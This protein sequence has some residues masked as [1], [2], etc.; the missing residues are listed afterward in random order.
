MACPQ[1]KSPNS[2][3]G[4]PATPSSARCTDSVSRVERC[5]RNQLGRCSRRRDNSGQLPNRRRLAASR[6][7]LWLRKARCL[8]LRPSA[9]WT[10]RLAR[11]RFSL[12]ALTCASGP[13]GIPL[14]QGSPSVDVGRTMVRTALSTPGWP[15]SP[16]RRRSVQVRTSSLARS[17]ATYKNERGL[18]NICGA[19]CHLYSE[20]RLFLF[21]LK[22]H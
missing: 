18:A 9:M 17:S 6:S 22:T 14:K 2:W 20:Q 4:L 16:L 7:R 13:S 5:P 15:T 19:P 12:W 8:F 3:V 1:A 21:K 10:R 11:R